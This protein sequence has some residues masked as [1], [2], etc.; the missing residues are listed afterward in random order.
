MSPFK[1][2]KEKVSSEMSK[3]QLFQYNIDYDRREADVQFIEIQLKTHL[4]ERFNTLVSSVEY[5]IVDGHLVR[6]GKKEPFIIS[7]MRGRDIIQKLNPVPADFERENAEIVGFRDIIDPLLCDPLA[8]LGRKILSISI[9][10]E[11]D[12]KYQHNFY[13][14][15]TL[16]M[17]NGKRYVQLSRYSSAL[18]A[19]N[20]AAILPDLDSEHPP[21]AA[22]F[23]AN[24]ILFDDASISSEQIHKMFHREH[25]YM[26]TSD[27]E[28]I[29]KEI[30]TS[31]FVKNY[32]QRK[33]ARSFNAILNFA[34]EVWENLKKKKR[35][36]GYRDYTSSPLTFAEKREMEERKIRQTITPCPGKS[37]ADISFPFSVSDFDYDYAFDQPG[38]C[39]S[40]GM[41]VSCGPCGLCRTCDIKIRREEILSAN[42]P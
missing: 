13:D 8:P 23:L 29:W 22:E 11:K 17:R 24:P 30:K 1:E 20:Y 16:K 28:E 37:G 2:D 41:N 38:P 12:S 31:P 15:F 5:E 40:C 6:P 33:D 25:E 39:K 26:E 3:E 7:I 14:I 42:Y 36:K 10:G 35:G 32:L 21:T 18:K 9:R 27:F 34:D 4:S 19:E